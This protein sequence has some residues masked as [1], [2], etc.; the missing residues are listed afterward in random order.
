MKAVQVLCG[1][2]EVI[3][4]PRKPFDEL[5]C[6]FLDELS[7]VLREDK[8][9]RNFADIMTLAFWIRKG[10]IKKK[11]DEYEKRQGNKFVIGRGIVFHIAPSNI[12]VNFMYSYLFGLL[13][14]N[15]NIV[16]VSTKEFPQVECICRILGDLLDDE[17][18]ESIKK[19]TS[20]I[21]YKRNKEI[22]DQ[23]S[24][25]C[26]VRIIWGGDNTIADIR[27]SPIPP[28]SLE[29]TFGD[30]YSFGILSVKAILQADDKEI[31]QLAQSFYNDTYLMDQNACST[32]HLLYWRLDGFS[33]ENIG[34]AKKKFWEA[35]VEVAEKYDLA[36]IKVSEKFE[37][38]CEIIM[39]NNIIKRVI[40]Y[41]N[42]LY[43]CDLK[44]LKKKFTLPIG[45]FG[46]FYQMDFENFN[47]IKYFI[48]ER[49]QTCAYY[50]VNANGI[51][52]WLLQNHFV[53]IDRVVPFG[54][55]LDIDIYWDG[56]DIINQLSRIVE[57]K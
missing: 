53:G 6:V 30:R 54:K 18:F 31:K 20:I 24:L 19:M 5:V 23:Y 38:I 1:V 39:E 9:A 36:D 42:I 27:N 51:L 44:K 2:E 48:N 33:E 25:N 12:P 26:N 14:G 55:T 57:M 35:V 28:R 32:P 11:K 45:K 4:R 47:E 7:A 41:N 43:I 29:I 13:A 15:S 34:G 3:K 52:E 22:T 8:E 50:G 16:R 21:R 49:V 56:Y 17:K 10:N 40:R 37:N 46:I